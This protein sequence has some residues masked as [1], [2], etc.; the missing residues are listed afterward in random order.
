MLIVKQ[1]MNGY[2]SM[3]ISNSILRLWLKQYNGHREIKDTSKGK[4]GSMTNGR[5]MTLNERIQ[6][7]SY[8]LEHNKNYRLAA[9]NLKVSYQ[10]V[11]QWVKKYEAGGEEV[12]KDKRGKNKTEQELKRLKESSRFDIIWS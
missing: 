10:Q 3:K 5:K 9:E 12:L 11:Y 4:T 7:V 6:A 8:C 2:I 1:F